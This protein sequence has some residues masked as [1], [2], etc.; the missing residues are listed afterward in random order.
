ME[1]RI[2]CKTI[3]VKG[4]SPKYKENMRLVCTFIDGSDDY[5]SIDG[6]QG[7]GDSYKRREKSLITIHIGGFSFEG[8]KDELE[9]KFMKEEQIESNK[10][11]ELFNHLIEEH[12]LILTITELEEIVKISKKIK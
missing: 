8:T 12:D 11:R 4:G 10:Y 1:S 6:F 2:S 3:G 9:N 5:I 7:N